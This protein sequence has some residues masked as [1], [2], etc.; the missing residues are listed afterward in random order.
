MLKKTKKK[1][2]K[3]KQNKTKKRVPDSSWG[4]GRLDTNEK[5]PVRIQVGLRKYGF[6]KKT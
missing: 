2:N 4:G 3:K 1:K 6:K 5:V